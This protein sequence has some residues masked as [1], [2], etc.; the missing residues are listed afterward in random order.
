MENKDQK[1]PDSKL[2]LYDEPLMSA[3]EW[4]QNIPE[5]L[6]A[7]RLADQYAKYHTEWHLN[8]VKEVVNNQPKIDIPAYYQSNL[9]DKKSITNAI[10]SYIDDN[11]NS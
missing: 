5:V 7:F 9:I 10:N 11:L 8:K 1:N 6:R 4:Y 2:G 3:E